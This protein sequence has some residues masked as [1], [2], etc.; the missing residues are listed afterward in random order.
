VQFTYCPIQARFID[1]AQDALAYYHF[2]FVAGGQ[3]VLQIGGVSVRLVF[4]PE[5]IHLFSAT[6]CP[7]PG[8]ELIQRPGSSELRYFDRTRAR[9]LDEVIHT[10]ERCAR[11][12]PGRTGNVCVYGPVGPDQRR[13]CVVV[14]ADRAGAYWYVRTA[15]PVSSSEFGRA[16]REARGKGAKWPP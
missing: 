2:R 7:A 11:A 8:T 3:R 13:M 12:L 14:G 5:E 15:Y 9:R 6:T 16:V 10:L 1:T 4:N